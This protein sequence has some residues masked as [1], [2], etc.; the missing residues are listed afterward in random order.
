MHHVFC[1]SQIRK[2]FNWTILLCFQN[3]ASNTFLFMR[4][5]QL[6]TFWFIWPYIYKNMIIGLVEKI[7]MFPYKKWFYFVNTLVHE[8]KKSFL[9]SFI[10]ILQAWCMIL[11]Q[12]GLHPLAVQESL[13]D[14]W[15]NG[16]GPPKPH[17]DILSAAKEWGETPT[18]LP[19][20][21]VSHQPGSV[22]VH[23]P[24]GDSSYIECLP[25]GG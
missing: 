2:W 4:G 25:P 21:L 18:M 22:G 1:F 5:G 11:V 10:Y 3:I 24:P 23:W 12:P 19:L 20:L 7:L 17:P 6:K 14:V 8:H 13:G 9:S 15:L 16:L